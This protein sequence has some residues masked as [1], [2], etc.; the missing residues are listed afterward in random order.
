M[1]RLFEFDEAAKPTDLDKQVLEAQQ[2]YKEKTVRWH[3]EGETTAREGRVVQAII[4]DNEVKLKVYCYDGDP[5]MSFFSYVS[6]ECVHLLDKNRR[7]QL[8]FIKAS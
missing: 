4:K 8:R 3:V 2:T 6:P 5:E 7:P 1:S